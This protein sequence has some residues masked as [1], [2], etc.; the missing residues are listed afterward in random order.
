MTIFD[1]LLIA[2][3]LGSAIALAAIRPF[4]RALLV[5]AFGLAIYLTVICI[6]SLGSEQKIMA[7]GDPDCS[8][9]WCVT[10]EKAHFAGDT[11]SVEFRVWSRAKRVTQREYG[12]RPFLVD[13]RG[14]RFL[15]SQSTGPEFDRSIG[16][17]DEFN[18][19]RTYRASRD[20]TTLDLIL[21]EG[22]GMETFVIGSSQS[23][24]HPRTVYR[25]KPAP[26]PV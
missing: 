20:A 2:V 3:I 12:V 4:R 11:V 21:R 15:I 16:P 23:L 9:D 14:Q 6:V 18:T 24:L 19:V 25:L 5:V 17:G 8:D 7:L 22:F 1:L 10:P 26:G 13:E